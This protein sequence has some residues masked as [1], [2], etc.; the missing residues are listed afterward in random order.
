MSNCMFKS[1]EVAVSLVVFV[2][3]KGFGFCYLW[4][5]VDELANH[6]WL[7]WGLNDTVDNYCSTQW[8][9]RFDVA[10]YKYYCSEL[11]ANPV[12]TTRVRSI[13]GGY[14]FSSSIQKG[15][16]PPGLWSQ[17]FSGGC[18]WSLVPGPFPGTCLSSPPS[19]RHLPP[20]GLGQATARVVRLLRSRRRTFSCYL[21]MCKLAE[22]RVV[23]IVA[24]L[25]IRQ[26]CEHLSLCSVWL[27]RRTPEVDGIRTGADG[28]GETLHGG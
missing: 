6:H 9:S 2:S 22:S 23:K 7:K 11:E 21:R 26:A 5:L 1:Q 10:V 3:F 13:T 12:F 16:V 14:V 15:W 20:P 18:P 4:Y 25:F 28:G 8:V 24:L 27:V 19:P 17:V